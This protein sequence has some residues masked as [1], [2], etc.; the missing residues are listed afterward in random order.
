MFSPTKR[1]D[2]CLIAD[3]CMSAHILICADAKSGY[4]VMVI[5]CLDYFAALGDCW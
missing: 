5:L 1:T 2:P 3:C 4:F